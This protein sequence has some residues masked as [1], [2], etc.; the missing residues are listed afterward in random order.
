N[1]IIDGGRPGDIVFYRKSGDRSN[2]SAPR[3]ICHFYPGTMIPFAIKANTFLE[4][5]TSIRARVLILNDMEW[6]K[7]IRYGN[8]RSDA[9]YGMWFLPAIAQM[10]GMESRGECP[11]LGA[12]IIET[13]R[14]IKGRDVD[15][16]PLAHPD[17]QINRLRPAGLA[18]PT[19]TGI[20]RFQGAA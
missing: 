6:L 15:L 11:D 7:N 4:N 2:R 13:V 18:L 20:A 17:W 1:F 10:Q 16:S 14:Q 19:D 3:E 8:I 5:I 9:Y 12:N